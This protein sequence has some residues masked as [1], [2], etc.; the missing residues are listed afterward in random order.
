M[1]HADA[2]VMMNLK[3]LV[4]INYFD[5]SQIPGLGD[6]FAVSYIPRAGEINSVYIRP[7]A[8]KYRVGLLPCNCKNGMI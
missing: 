7:V 2:A 6:L 8:A 3:V 4:P 1:F 5:M